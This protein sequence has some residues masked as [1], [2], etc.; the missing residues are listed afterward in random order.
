M[1]H[2]NA[3][4]SSRF[5]S[6]DWGTSM[7]RLRLVEGADLVVTASVESADGIA[8]THA[9]WNEARGKRPAREAFYRAVLRQAILTLEEKRGAKL[10]GLPLVISGMASSSIG[11]AD[12]SYKKLPF[13]IDGSDLRTKRIKATR[14][15]AHDMLLIS[16]ARDTGDVMRGE[17]VQ[18]VGALALAAPVAGDRLLVF[19]GTHSKHVLVKGEWA[20]ALR[21]Y[22]TGEIFDLLARHSVLANSVDAKG[23]LGAA[24]QRHAFEHGVRVGMNQNLLHALFS[25]RVR[26]VLQQANR[27]E[28]FHYLSGLVL[29]CEMKD[30]AP[31]DLGPPLIVA[32]PEAAARYR[33]AMSAAGIR[34]SIPEVGVEHALITGQAR[35][36]ER[37][38]IYG[39]KKRPSELHV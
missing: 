3:G 30:L 21:T 10:S 22:M 13:A 36:A 15:F 39:P 33:A 37:A 2:L 20:I 29:G 4:I 23:T 5:L 35:I 28:N 32:S 14:T 8:A 24:A 9:R 7:L 6:C 38:G 19:P 18:L 12:V 25:V 27:S 11:M 16:G 34:G 1:F 26:G 31:L 17:E